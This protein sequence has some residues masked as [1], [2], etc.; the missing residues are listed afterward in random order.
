MAIKGESQI[1]NVR[2]ARHQRSDKD[3]D[4]MQTK[5]KKSREGQRLAHVGETG[6]GGL[7]AARGE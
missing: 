6:K 7:A 2:R 3:G 1:E 5:N 4:N